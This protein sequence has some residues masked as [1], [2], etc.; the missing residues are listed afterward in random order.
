MPHT[1][2]GAEY[3]RA[4]RTML[5]YEREEDRALVIAAGIRPEW[6][7]NDTGVGVKR[8]PTHLGAL[9]YRL[10]KTDEQTLQLDLTGDLTVPPGGIVLRSPLPSPIAAVTVNGIEHETFDADEVRIDTFPAVV[11]IGHGERMETGGQL[12]GALQQGL[13]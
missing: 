5:V 7:D 1:W 11:E 2:V 3:I 8:L 9:N 4:I 13:Q 12:N 6:L 10:R